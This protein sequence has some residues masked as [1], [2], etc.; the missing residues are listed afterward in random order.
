MPALYKLRLGQH[1][2]DNRASVVTQVASVFPNEGQLNNCHWSSLAGLRR[3]PGTSFL[4][5]KKR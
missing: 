5:G 4:G 1:T 3:P 2:S